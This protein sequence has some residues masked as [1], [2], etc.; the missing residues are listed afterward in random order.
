[1]DAVAPVWSPDGERLLYASASQVDGPLQMR[2]RRSDGSGTD[3]DVVRTVGAQLPQDWSSDGRVIL[4]GDRVVVVRSAARRPA[5]ALWLVPPDGSRPPEPL[6]PSPVSRAEGRFSPDGRYVAF[7]S[8][9]AGRPEVI[10]APLGGAGRRQQVSTEGGFAPRWRRDGRELFYFSPAGKM[11]S[12]SLEKGP[13]GGAAPPVPLFA[14]PGHPSNFGSG[15]MTAGLRYDVDARRDRFLIALA[16][17][18]AP[19]ISVAVG[20]DAR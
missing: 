9:E 2:V 8:D 7:V 17:E 18:G 13:D 11:M 15:P 20:W 10:V 1:L 12:V 19:P 14:L 5:R 6:E 16:Q 3:V 4:F